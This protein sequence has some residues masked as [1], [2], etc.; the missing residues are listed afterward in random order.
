MRCLQHRRER[1]GIRHPEHARW[2]VL[3]CVVAVLLFAGPGFAADWLAPAA[4]QTVTAPWVKNVTAKLNE[5]P[6][7]GVFANSMGEPPHSAIVRYLNGAADAIQAGN[8]PL[9]E[10]Y[11]DRTIA[12]FDNGVRKGNY[13]RAEVEPIKQLIRSAAESAMKGGQVAAAVE[14]EERWAGYT[15]HKPL[16]LANEDDRMKSGHSA[17]N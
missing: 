13:M 4:D 9:A 8:K 17:V 10:S 5:E 7:R 14:D 16:G 1:G 15:Q 11:V 6:Y 12:I 2:S 3:G